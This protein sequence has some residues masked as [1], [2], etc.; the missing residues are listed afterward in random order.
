MTLVV[1]DPGHGGHESG[2]Q[3]HGLLEKELNLRVCLFLREALQR[4]GIEVL[5]TRERDTECV[6]GVRT[7]VD[8]RARA[9][10]ANTRGADLFLSWH[11]EVSPDPNRQ[12]VSAWIHTADSGRSPYY[13]AELLAWQ[14]ASACGQK[15]RGVY[16]G[17]LQVL[18]ETMM[19]SVLITAG[20]LTHAGEALR[21]RQ[22]S[23]L[24][25]Q[26]EA[27]AMAVCRLLDKPYREPETSSA[28]REERRRCVLA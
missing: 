17:D 8:L 21:L 27:A 2:V 1:L 5:M 10:F 25:Q 4:A 28:R 7:E 14:L 15:N 12:G 19:D 24:R 6:P 3:A 23:F 9:M 22:D 20:V 13:K 26:A 18:R 11:Y 16:L